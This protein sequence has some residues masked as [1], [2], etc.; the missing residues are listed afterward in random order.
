MANRQLKNFRS[1][2]GKLY[3]GVCAALALG[4]AFLVMHAIY[5]S[6][7]YLTL[8]RQRREYKATEQRIRELEQEKVSLE[9]QVKDLKSDPKAIERV[10]REKMHLARPGEIIYTLPQR[11]S[12]GGK[13]PPTA[14]KTTSP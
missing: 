12:S 5:G 14:S 13:A 8:R 4:C 2:H 9:Q 11:D 3:W 1:E 7:G 10:A 6:N